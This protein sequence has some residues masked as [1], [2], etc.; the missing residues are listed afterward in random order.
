MSS[1]PLKEIMD[2][3]LGRPGAITPK[4]RDYYVGLA[5]RK[6]KVRTSQ[7]CVACL[8]FPLPT[9]CP[10]RAVPLMWPSIYKP[11]KYC[12]VQQWLVLALYDNWVVPDID[13]YP[14]ILIEVRLQ[15]PSF[16]ALRFDIDRAVQ[17]RASVGRQN[18]KEA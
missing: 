10:G 8:H 18:S 17:I 9:S 11:K 1:G 3:W 2:I 7:A 12:L 13:F 6:G 4:E 16:E 15:S 5:W 14:S